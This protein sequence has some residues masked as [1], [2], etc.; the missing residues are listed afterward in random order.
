M[1][2][3][4][5]EARCTVGRHHEQCLDSG[6]AL[7]RPR[8]EQLGC[9]S[10]PVVESTIRGQ[11]L[12]T[13]G[14]RGGRQPVEGSAV[15]VCDDPRCSWLMPAASEVVTAR[16]SSP[17]RRCAVLCT[18]ASPAARVEHRHKTGPRRFH[19]GNVPQWNV[20]GAADRFKKP[21]PFLATQVIAAI[22]LSVF[23]V[24]GILFT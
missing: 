23:V 16:N 10:S 5:D 21:L 4:Q 19:W 11:P 12:R 14:D 8:F 9:C 17:R 18:C 2:Q 1:S 24:T 20:P 15:M 7:Q 6:V 3:R 22:G 13:F